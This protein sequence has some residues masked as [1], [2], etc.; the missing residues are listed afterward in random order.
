MKISKEPY[1]FLP[2]P[3]GEKNSGKN[4]ALR[5]ASQPDKSYQFFVVP[6]AGNMWYIEVRDRI[7]DVFVGYGAPN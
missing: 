1:Y 4:A 5:V 3:S 2:N 7:T 6:Y